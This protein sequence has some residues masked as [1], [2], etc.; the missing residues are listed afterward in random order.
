MLWKKIESK[1]VL[2][3]WASFCSF[4]LILPSGFC[5]SQ[6]DWPQFHGSHRDRISNESDW[7]SKWSGKEPEIKWTKSAGIGFSSFSVKNGR[8]FT[9]GN[10]KDRDAVWCFDAETGQ[11]IWRYSY[12][13]ELFPNMHE[14]GPGCTPT[15]DEESVYTISKDGQLYCLDVKSGKERWKKNI[16][17][18]YNTTMPTWRF[19]VSPLLD[20]DRIIIDVGPTVALNKKTGDAVWITEN[21]ESAYSS[22]ISFSMN[23][24]Q[25]VAV[26]PKYGLV[27]LDLKTGK[28][29]GKF[30]WE[31]S[32][33]INA[34][35]PLIFENKVFI[36]SGYS[37]GGSLLE[38]APSGEMKEIWHNRLLRNHM[39]ACVLWKGFLYGFDESTLK[40]V[41]V[42]TGKDVWMDRSLGK[43]SLMLADGK[44][45]VLGETGE[46]AVAEASEKG[47]APTGRKKV[48]SGRCW[49]IPVLSNGK[50]FCRNAA[51]DVVCLDVKKKS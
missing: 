34:A 32:Y 21:Y 7:L 3:L 25:Y 36:S 20:G 50:I 14:G 9:M 38:I 48:L 47:F 45:I 42:K 17:K 33:G 29:F 5:D 13:C 49:T 43:G 16:Q 24:V 28:E 37:K 12:D 51:G 4:F 44:L 2:F 15:V 11:E 35:T 30:P 26:L 6:W 19:A 39:N 1:Q 31:T 10:E 22:P 41:D 23:G 46:L 8:V 27:I 40:C 18:E